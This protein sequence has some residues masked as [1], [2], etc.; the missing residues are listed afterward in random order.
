MQMQYVL[1]FMPFVF[2]LAIFLNGLT[3]LWSKE[4]NWWS[5]VMVGIVIILA[6]IMTNFLGV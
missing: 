1:F 5:S 4:E 6:S 3:K 2:G